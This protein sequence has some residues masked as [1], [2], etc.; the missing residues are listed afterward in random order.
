MRVATIP[1]P[2]DQDTRAQDLHATGVVGVQLLTG[3]PPGAP[4]PP[5]PLAPLLTSLVR[6]PAS[7]RPSAADALARLR[8]LDLVQ[9]P[10]WGRGTAV[11]D[12]RDRTGPVRRPTRRRTHH[13]TAPSAAP[14]TAP[15]TGVACLLLAA[16]LLL[17][18]LRVLAG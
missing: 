3:G 4:V 18:A 11:P 15:A 2:D 12:V 7:G 13:S 6:P 5:G 9:G 16:V 8:A 1:D 14:A 17:T 10:P